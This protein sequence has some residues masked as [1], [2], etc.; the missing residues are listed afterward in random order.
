MI[1]EQDLQKLFHQI[2]HKDVGSIS[3]N[4]STIAVRV[5]E[6]DSLLSLT[7]PVY[8]GGNY[9][10]PS[11]RRCVSEKNPPFASDLIKTYLTLNEENFEITLNYMGLLE[12]LDRKKFKDL[13]EEFSWI[14]EEWR[15][16]LDE[17]DRHDLIHVR[18]Q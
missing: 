7:T 4:G 2:V 12:S 14:A 17:H 9:I 16:Y 3:L 10:P 8:K 6:Q 15:G 1:T 11:V 13:L 5:F 18:V